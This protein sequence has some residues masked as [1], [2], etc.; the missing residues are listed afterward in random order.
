M[1]WLEIHADLSAVALQI[2]RIADALDRAVPPVGIPKDR[3]EHPLIGRE[4]IST[5]TPEHAAEVAAKRATMPLDNQAQHVHFGQSRAGADSE[6]APDPSR[7]GEW[8]HDDPL[9]TFPELG[10]E[11]PN[12][13]GVDQ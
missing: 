10:R 3:R 12:Y 6:A 13:S 11:W 1:A 2:K 9:D 4:D 7:T 5:M 8:D